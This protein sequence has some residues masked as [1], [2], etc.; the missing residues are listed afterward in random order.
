MDI[1]MTPK[2]YAIK[3]DSEFLVNNIELAIS[4]NNLPVGMDIDYALSVLDEAKA[5]KK[6]DTREQWLNR[7]K[8][9]M[10]KTVF[11]QAGYKEEDFPQ[12]RITCAP[13]GS[14]KTK[15]IGQCYN[16][17]LS[18]DNT[19]EIVISSEIGHD[20]QLEVISI[21]AHEIIHALVG[22]EAQHG[23]K[24][25]KVAL[26]I[27]LEG[28]MTATVAGEEFKQAT[29]ALLVKLG[30]YPH[31]SMKRGEKK[32]QTTRMVKLECGDCG[33]ICR[34]SRSAIEASGEPTCG[35][36]GEMWVA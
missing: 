7:A 26:A 14:R 6:I 8:D 35:C 12:I 4:Q 24:F 15:T 19:F 20:Q 23:P 13:I 31:A 28:K 3:N 36:G 18:D 29:Q 32:K 17:T 1:T 34:A 16:N 25:R 2:E 11:K 27:G 22:L 9:G 21:L 5:T 33:F 10:I 30:E